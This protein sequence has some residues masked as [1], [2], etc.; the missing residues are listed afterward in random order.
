MAWVERRPRWLPG[1]T[2]RGS[3]T[4][5]RG[6][7]S[8]RGSRAAPVLA[9]AALAAVG[10]TACNGPTPPGCGGVAGT[11]VPVA[12]G[13]G[14]SGSAPVR[15]LADGL[16]H[17]LA[18]AAR[19]LASGR[20]SEAMEAADGAERVAEVAL[21]ASSGRMQDA[22]AR[23]ASALHE[24]RRDVQTGRPERARRTLE[25]ASRRLIAE[26]AGA[27]PL[28]PRAESP[29]WRRVADDARYCG[30]RLVDA[31]GVPIG[32]V[33][34]FVRNADDGGAGVDRVVVAIG[35]RDFLGFW[36]VS[37]R[38]VAVPGTAIVLGPARTVGTT[39][40]ALADTV[41]PSGLTAR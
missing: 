37:G 17:G 2:L 29:P 36:D 15:V 22:I 24:A 19:G 7:A 8:P 9:L 18:R 39:L 16:A 32:E 33:V 38:R 1:V 5:R 31:R 26:A 4:P 34:G 25:E 11:A 23:A 41:D 35:W 40:L 21:F 14:R 10:A 30:A 20:R 28:P 6:S 3:A 13:V 12:T 27:G